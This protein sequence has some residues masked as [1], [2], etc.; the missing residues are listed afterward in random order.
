MKRGQRLFFLLPSDL[1]IRKR[2]GQLPSVCERLQS[3]CPLL[4]R[5]KAE[6]SVIFVLGTR[7]WSPGHDRLGQRGGLSRLRLLRQSLWKGV[8]QSVYLL[9]TH[10]R[11][12]DSSD[13]G[14]R[15]LPVNDI[16]LCLPSHGSAKT[17]S[18]ARLLEESARRYLIVP[19]HAEAN[20]LRTPFEEE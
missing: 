1:L 10:E 12:G 11:I 8:D 16:I 13:W 2:T 17:P 19:P 4:G 14:T 7:M 18:G 5:E 3:A 20:S 6:K 9:R 15:L